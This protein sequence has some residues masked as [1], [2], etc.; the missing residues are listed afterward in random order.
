MRDA[1]TEGHFG[2]GSVLVH[3]FA[4]REYAHKKKATMAAYGYR[5]PTHAASMHALPKLLCKPKS[6]MTTYMSAYMLL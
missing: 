4:D 2:C 1:P 5:Y 6:Y 3:D